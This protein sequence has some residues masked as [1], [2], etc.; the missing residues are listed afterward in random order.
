MELYMTTRELQ[1]TPSI[2]VGLQADIDFTKYKYFFK[3]DYKDNSASKL[4]IAGND[5]DEL[6][7]Y[8]RSHPPHFYEM[9][10][11]DVPVREYVDIDYIV[12]R[13]LNEEEVYDYTELF[14]K[15]YLDV[16]NEIITSCF[17]EGKMDITSIKTIS[18]KE[19]FVLTSHRPTEKGFKISLHIVSKVTGFINNQVQRLFQM[20]VY[21]GMMEKGVEGVIDNSVYSKNRCMRLLG[22]SKRG[23]SSKLAVWNHTK[24]NSV[25]FKDTFLS[26]HLPDD[27]K[28][29]NKYNIED[30][31]IKQ[32]IQDF[33]CVED[34]EIVEFL[35][36][37]EE[38]E[39]RCESEHFIKLNRIGQSKCLSGSKIHETQDACIYKTNGNT[40][41]RCYCAEGKPI[42][43]GGHPTPTP[44]L[45]SEKRLLSKT[46]ICSCRLG[47]D[48]LVKIM[49]YLRNL[50]DYSNVFLFL[51]GCVD[52]SECQMKLLDRLIDP[53]D[54][55]HQYIDH[56]YSAFEKETSSMTWEDLL[57][58][59]LVKDKT[60]VLK[61]KKT[62]QSIRLE[63]EERKP[64]ME[65]QVGQ[66]FSKEH[67]YAEFNR[68]LINSRFDSFDKAVE[69]FN[70]NV[71]KYIKFIEHPKMYIVNQR[72]EQHAMARHNLTLST[73]Y[74]SGEPEDPKWDTL[75]FLRSNGGGLIEEP[76]VNSIIPYYHTKTFYPKLNTSNK[77]FAYNTFQG[78]KAEEVK[79]VD[80]ELIQP[81]L[82]HILEC[83]ANGDDDLYDYVMEWFKRAWTIP[84]VKIGVVLLIYGKEG[85]GKSSL[86]DDF[87]IPFIYGHQLAASLQGI[88]QLNA[89]FNGIAEDKLF[90][91]CNELSSKEH[92]ASSTNKLKK[93]ITDATMTIQ[94]KYMDTYIA[95]NYINF[96][97]CTNYRVPLSLSEADR[98]YCCLE[99]SDKFIGCQDYF[100]SLRLCFTQESANH[101]FTYVIREYNKDKSPRYLQA[102][103]MTNIKEEM[104]D[105]CKPSVVKFIDD[106]RN[107]YTK[108]R[109]A[110]FIYET[111]QQRRNNLHY[112]KGFEDATTWQ[113]KLA[114]HM[115][116]DGWVSSTKLYEI[117]LIYCMATKEKEVK[118]KVF[119]SQLKAIG[120]KDKRSNGTK[121]NV[122]N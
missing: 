64:K 120:V 112:V 84:W 68:T 121:Y 103:P 60:L 42:L 86:L 111:K 97:F 27:L 39:F 119:C 9:I 7:D 43:I 67:H 24:Y 109:W 17:H 98:R 13:D 107:S 78:F 4:T 77:E 33:D 1:S 114:E 82:T 20:D 61:I 80:M 66:P 55:P 32:H 45:P 70:T 93:F 59:K 36:K 10:K 87:I 95:D 40:F 51:K 105:V 35:K 54:I 23:S 49:K 25:Q 38:Y 113:M 46:T 81:I 11:D 15:Q 75:H 31:E 108:E 21:R 6:V 96:I 48:D 22:M 72:G 122:F 100:K 115:D 116:I 5:L 14:I 91:N 102:I 19:I 89:D 50:L 117:F 12:D 18:Q 85:T 56:L 104:I 2:Q 94:K 88:D 69:F 90:L 3:Y 110:K 37:H 44:T 65:P 26:Y 30:V 92:I 57:K 41:F 47:H 62:I 118:H 76:C 52:R 28:M 74:N 83:W 71:D 101:F 79:E 8:I 29:V 63:E 99:T 106:I 73:T 34:D 53:S 16:R 58:N